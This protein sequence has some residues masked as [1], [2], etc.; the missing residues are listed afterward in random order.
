MATGNA[1]LRPALAVAAAAVLWGLWWVP[2]RAL[3][4]G[5]FTGDW[6]SLAL[7]GLGVAVLLPVALARRARLAAGGA[8][9][10][11]I[12]LCF[13]VALTVWNH[14]LLTGEVVRVVL[15]F[16]LCPI[17][18]TGFALVILHQPVGLPRVAAI[19]LGLAG[20]VVV[21]GLEGGAPLPR[22]GA[23]WMA[24]AAGVLFAL[25]ATI[26]RK[27]THCG[28][29]EKIFLSFLV[30]VVTALVLIG[31]AP[32]GT[33]PASAGLA[34][35]LPLLVGVTALWLL[36]QTWLLI[37]GAE[38]LDPGRVSL[39]M[40][41]EIVAAVVSA[42]LFAGEPFGWREFAGCLLIL[43]AGAVEAYDQHRLAAAEP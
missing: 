22:A 15:L 6:V 34:H 33:A 26:T 5:G 4:E 11:V 35:A 16:Y 8:D 32:A 9:L 30:A 37:W 10:L 18:A 17:W 2:V 13:G 41:L 3:A 24:I 31:V 43:G 27:A 14:A 12:G 1:A 36:P 40:L 29:F 25:G 28:S 42:A 23:E 19:G 7:Y 39:L 20:A 21:L 38:R